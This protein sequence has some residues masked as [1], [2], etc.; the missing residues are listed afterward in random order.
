MLQP[1]GTCLSSPPWSP[2][3]WRPTLLW[4]RLSFIAHSKTQAF[5]YVKFM[6]KK[7]AGMFASVCPGS[8]DFLLL[9]FSQKSL[10]AHATVVPDTVIHRVP[11]VL[12][13]EHPG[14]GG[15]ISPQ[16]SRVMTSAHSAITELIMPTSSQRKQA[17]I[18][19]LIQ[20]WAD[21]TLFPSDVL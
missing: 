14:G 18:K 16:D 4:L 1:F 5:A 8:D 17:K 2:R 11:Q 19:V 10:T 20:W 6:L 12:L 3:P 21:D 9:F 15:W 7:R 13:P